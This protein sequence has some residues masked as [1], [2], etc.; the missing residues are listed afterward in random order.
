[1]TTDKNGYTWPKWYLDRIK[2]ND[3]N[4]YAELMCKEQK[5]EE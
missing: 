1:M 4:R 5:K 2:K 3:P